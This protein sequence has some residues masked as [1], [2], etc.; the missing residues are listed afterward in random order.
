M[1]ALKVLGTSFVTNDRPGGRRA[2]RSPAGFVVGSL[3][4]HDRTH[5]TPAMH[6][7]SSD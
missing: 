7:A 1:T 4:E 3:E 6:V 5:P 2:G